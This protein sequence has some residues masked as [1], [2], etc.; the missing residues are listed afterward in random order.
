M[1]FKRRYHC[2]SFVGIDPYSYKIVCRFPLEWP[3]DGWTI[4]AF[5]QAMEIHGAPKH[6]ISDQ[7]PVF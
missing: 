3:N 4:T 1:E 6:M 5:E 7:E 2:Y